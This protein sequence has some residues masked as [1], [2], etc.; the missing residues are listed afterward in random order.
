MQTIAVPEWKGLQPDYTTW[1][2]KSAFIFLLTELD[3]NQFDFFC[4]PIPNGL[5]FYFYGASLVVQWL[6]IHLLM[7][8]TWV[9]A[10]VP[11]D[12]TCCRAAKPVRHN[13]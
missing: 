6:R 4:F 12:P 3:Q 7:Q 1:M 9:R 10:L 11:E 8:G 2:E 5:K 13:Y